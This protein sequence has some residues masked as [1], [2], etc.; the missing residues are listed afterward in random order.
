[1]EQNIIAII[2][3]VIE[4]LFLV[5]G[6]WYTFNR[7]K[8]LSDYEK[9]SDYQNASVDVFHRLSDF[10]A[11]STLQRAVD[12]IF[13]NTK[14]TRFLVLMAA[15]KKTYLNDVTALYEQHWDT[16]KSV[17]ALAKYHHITID[18]SYRDMLKEAELA[19]TYIVDVAEMDDCLL[20]DIYITEGIKHS[21]VTFL[22]RED[23]SNNTDVVLFTTFATHDAEPFSHIERTELK[24]IHE[25]KILPLIK[26]L[27]SPE[28]GM[29]INDIRIDS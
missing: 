18:Q 14:A 24:L 12:N 20:K 1:M 27:F 9:R 2:V 5:F 29:L 19:G 23:V 10:N 22:H 8:K 21:I 16:G 13:K 4:G 6:V 25:T 15:N 17:N 28:H 3:A 11:I 26:Q 7:N